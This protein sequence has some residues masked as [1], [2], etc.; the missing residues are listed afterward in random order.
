LHDEHVATW[1]I[2]REAEDARDERDTL[3]ARGLQVVCVPCVE[4]SSL[5]WPWPDAG[6]EVVTFFTSRRAVTSWLEAGRPSLGAVAAVAPATAEALEAAGVKPEV[7]E[8]G[9]VV[10]LA[11]AVLSWWRARGCPRTR[12]HYPTSNAGLHAPEQ[13]EA[14]RL[15][16]KLV[17][18]DRQLAYEV[19][20]P[21][22]LQQ[23]LEAAA[24]GA[25]AV[26]FSSPSAV[27]HFFSAGARIAHPPV[28][29]QCRGGSTRR[30]WNKARPEGWPEV[31]P[32]HPEVLS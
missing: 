7:R 2:T 31:E 4:T 14:L 12:V 30:A 3:E 20:A 1:L 26:T 32:S 9:G 16:S 6:D 5:P 22:G 24:R 10:A 13:S 8:A 28:E 15:L 25:W 29:V 18:V 19:R 11:Q 17:E 27:H 21:E 23:Q